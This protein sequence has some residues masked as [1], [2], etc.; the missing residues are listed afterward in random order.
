MKRLTQ[1]ALTLALGLLFVNQ[2]DAQRRYLEPSFGVETSD[3]QFAG[4]N[5]TV[6]PW[7]AAAQQGVA[8]NTARQPLPY[9]LFEPAGD[10]ETERP[11]I[12]YMHTGNFFP[13]PLN[14]SC[15]GTIT[16][17]TNI[18]MAGRLASMGYVV[19]LASYRQGWLPTHPQ[20]LVRRFSLINGA[21]RGVQDVNTYIRHFKATSDV[22]GIDPDKIVVWGQGTG[23]YL[24][25]ATAYLNQ[26]E[27]IL[28]TSDPNKFLLPNPTGGTIPMIIPAYNGD[29]GGIGDIGNGPGHI[30]LVDTTYSA[31]SS[32]PVGDT[33]FTP[34]YE[35]LT[36]INDDFALAVN[37][38]GALGDSTWMS[39]GEVPIISVHTTFDP[40]APYETDVLLVPTATG[41]QPVVEVS[42]SYDVQRIA[43]RLGLN[44]IFN[45]IPAGNDPI[46]DAINPEFPGLF[47]IN[48]VNGAQEQSAPWEWVNP[49]TP[50]LIPDDCPTDR[51]FA[52]TVIDSIIMFYAPRACVALDLACDFTVSTTEINLDAGDMTIA[53]NPAAES[54]VITTENHSL[55]AVTVYDLRGQTIIANTYDGE[56]HARIDVNGLQPGMYIVKAHVEDGVITQRV[57]IQ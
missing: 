54:F 32:L 52:L 4:T 42:G 40:F 39:A 8:G 23:G 19:A 46:G 24:S 37:T 2:V 14:G 20:E 3:V 12:I 31:V 29:I 30:G 44:D 10:T 26:Y 55:E 34:N 49:D 1:Y 47:A 17:S 53:P 27:E 22:V 38:G 11:L 48:S 6:L 7:I 51:E 35:T 57:M 15:S 33:L 25:L 21:Y 28:Q 43:T 45:T 16:D 9:L 18:A 36:D 41:P 50:G 56:S 13:F 5:F